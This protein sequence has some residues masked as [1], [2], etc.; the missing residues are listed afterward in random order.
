MHARYWLKIWTQDFDESNHHIVISNLVFWRLYEILY[1]DLWRQANVR[2]WYFDVVLFI[3]SSANWR[4]IGIHYWMSSV[5]IDLTV[6]ILQRVRKVITTVKHRG[7]ITHPCHNFQGGLVKTPL[8]L[9]HALIITSAQNHG[10][11]IRYVKLRVRMR[12]ECRERFP[13]HS[14]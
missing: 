14:G 3:L 2:H 1:V 4:K 11:L 12:R 9:G 7:V 10:S 6:F 5:N 13:S 8:E